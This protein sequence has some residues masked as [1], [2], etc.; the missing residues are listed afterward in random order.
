[1]DTVD[2][3]IVGGQGTFREGNYYTEY[4][5]REL[6]LE[7]VMRIREIVEHFR[8]SVVICSGGYTQGETPELSEAESIINIWNE[9]Q[10]TPGCPI[11]LDKIALDSA[12]N[13]VFGL[14]ALR[15][16]EPRATLGRIGFFSQWHFKKQRMTSLAAHLGIDKCFFFHGHADAERSNAGEDAKTGEVLQLEQMRSRNDYLLSGKEW[17]EKRKKRHRH[18]TIPYSERDAELRN[19]FPKVFDALD[20]L[21]STSVKELLAETNEMDTEVLEALSMVQKRKL[22]ALQVAFKCEVVGPSINVAT[23]TPARTSDVPG[24]E[25]HSNGSAAP[26]S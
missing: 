19:A 25:L 23:P 5:D 11:V 24:H 9:T 3:L 16:K 20:H 14:M 18:V 21:T 15:L 22:H 10:T 4:P 2:A 26:V 6:S 12:E 8:Y 1:M 17:E 13:V 7:Y